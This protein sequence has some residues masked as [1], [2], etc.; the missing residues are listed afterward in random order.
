ML[1][2]DL[3]LPDAFADNTPTLHDI[4]AAVEKERSQIHDLT[5]DFTFN[6]TQPPSRP[7][8]VGVR[9]HALVTVKGEMISI[10]TENGAAPETNPKLF[11][12]DKAYNG[13][14]ATS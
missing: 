11:V 3:P 8:F 4:A 2:F 7:G 13:H 9:F 12:W 10:H 5:V 1:S 14:R 6:A